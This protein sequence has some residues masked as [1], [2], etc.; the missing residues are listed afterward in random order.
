MPMQTAI[1]RPDPAT[2]ILTGEGCWILELWNTPAD[3]AAS[4]ARARVTPGVTTELHRL[5]GV[6][7]RYVILAGRGQMSVGSL[8][9][10][11]VGPGDVVVIPADIP[12]RIFNDGDADLVFLCICTPRFTPECY[13]AVPSAH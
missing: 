3:G 12:Q 10:S 2:E 5:R 1:H 8:A 7:E 9:P 11:R 4:I 6:E 13:E